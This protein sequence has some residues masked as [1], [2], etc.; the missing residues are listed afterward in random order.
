MRAVLVLE[1]TFFVLPSILQRSFRFVRLQRRYLRLVSEAA[2]LHFHGRPRA[3]RRRC[4]LQERLILTQPFQSL[5]D[6][7]HVLVVRHH[8]LYC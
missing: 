3:L 1:L 5:L 6:G 7:S 4:R 8:C 2:L